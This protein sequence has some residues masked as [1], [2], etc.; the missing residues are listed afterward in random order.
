MSHTLPTLSKRSLIP[1]LGITLVILAA[2][3][4]DAYRTM[5]KDWIRDENYSHGFLVPLVSAYFIYL[6][7]E[8][9]R[10][11]PARPDN[12]GLVFVLGGIVMYILGTV[13]N[14]V[15]TARV[16]SIVVISGLILFFW[17]REAMR[18][19]AMPVAYLL[20]MVP[21][22]AIIYN[23]VAF[24]LKL[25]ATQCATFSLKLF[26]LPVLREGNIIQFPNITLEVADACSGM[27][28]LMS[29]IALGVALAFLFFRSN[30]RR[31]IIILSTVPIAIATNVFRIFATGVLARYAGREAAEGFFHEFAGMMV[32]ILAMILLMSLCWVIGK[33]S[34]EATASG[35]PSDDPRDGTRNQAQNG[36]NHVD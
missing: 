21:I 24:P 9:L 13:G 7:R 6:K 20:L 8:A 35:S 1:L 34:P 30:W 12:L 14:E 16:S 31:L 25:F 4:A 19:L 15:F 33:I 2:M 22:P 10:R 27:R 29:L 18:E 26:G 3:Y 11:I 5:V 17:G 23:A 36:G 28:S 32:F